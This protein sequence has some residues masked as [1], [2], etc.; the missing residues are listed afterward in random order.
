[1]GYKVSQREVE[2]ETVSLLKSLLYQSLWVQ[3]MCLY[4]SQWIRTWRRFSHRTGTVHDERYYLLFVC[5]RTFSLTCPNLTNFWGLNNTMDKHNTNTI[6]NYIYYFYLGRNDPYLTWPFAG[7]R[8]YI[9]INHLQGG[10]HYYWNNSDSSDN[11]F[12]RPPE[13]RGET[14]HGCPQFISH[15]ELFHQTEEVQ[16]LKDD[17]L[18]IRI[19]VKPNE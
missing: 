4:C 13:E 16:Y 3:G 19:I 5:L 8:K 12:Q 10:K 11:A 1:M 14:G 15:K 2:T 7:T 18:I 9:L 17:T 6:L